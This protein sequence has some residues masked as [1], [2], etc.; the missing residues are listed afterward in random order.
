MEINVNSKDVIWSYLSILI[1]MSSN[2]IV[3]PFIVFYLSGEMLGL[4]YV[5]VSIGAIA[6]LFDF[7]FAPTF[8]RNITYCWSGAKNL[9]KKGKTSEVYSE[10][11]FLLMNKVLTT[12]K[13]IYFLLA[14]AVLLLLISLGTLY[15]SHITTNI[16]GY[17]HY[18]AWGFYVIGVF[19]NLYYNYY[20]SF[21]RGVGNVQQSQKNRVIAKT[22]QII[23]MILLLSVGAGIIGVC[24][25]YLLF[26]IVF[27]F[28]GKHHFYHYKEIGKKLKSNKS[29]IDRLEFICLFKTIWYNAWR[30]GLIQ[31]T[32]YCTEQASVLICSLYL[33]LEETGVYSLSLQIANAVAMLASAL[34][35]TYQPTIQSA[36]INNNKQII[37]ES[38]SVIV[39]SLIVLMVLGVL[40]TIFVALPLLRLIK[41]SAVVEISLLLGIFLNQFF[42]RYRNSYSSYFSCT[43]RLIYMKSFILS[44]ILC[45]ALSFILVGIFD[46][47]CWGLVTAQII[48]QLVYNVW[49]WSLKAHIEL[50]YSLKDT[51][52]IGFESVRQKFFKI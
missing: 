14:S 22:I 16:T 47:G 27:R 35:L 10:P 21:L 25:A 41:P 32:I 29:D 1:T 26:G 17:S 13:R 39:F 6:N 50:E 19:L 20:D 52:I 2:I 36:Y 23:S 11:D 38:M 33:C 9:E 7:G 46:W 43:N 18:I 28:L 12:C 30:E 3:I 37:R 48:S 42:L 45:I 40:G 24:M 5:F 51:F 8:A 4:W 44:A 49:Y 34:Y 31:I 15:I